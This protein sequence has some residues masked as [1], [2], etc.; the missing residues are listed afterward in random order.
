MSMDSA[1][2][3]QRVINSVGNVFILHYVH[4][5]RTKER[6]QQQQAI[7]PARYP[8]PFTRHND[9]TDF[10]QLGRINVARHGV[11]KQSVSPTLQSA[12]APAPAPTSVSVSAPSG[13]FSA[14]ATSASTENLHR[15][16][17]RFRHLLQHMLQQTHQ[18]WLL[19]LLQCRRR[20]LHHKKER[21][22]CIC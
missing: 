18:F 19:Y 5:I 20:P 3:S 4:I 17:H 22:Y 13:P 1:Q 8:I 14:Y 6:K 7:L 21:T 2:K 9:V 11:L 10:P 16:R 12:S 15:H